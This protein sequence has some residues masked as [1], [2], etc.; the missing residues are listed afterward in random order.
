MM[1]ETW[2]VCNQN[3][4]LIGGDGLL[5]ETFFSHSISSSINSVI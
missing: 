5:V 4:P 2:Y 1:G 3:I